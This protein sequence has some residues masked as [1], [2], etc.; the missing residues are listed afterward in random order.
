MKISCCW[1]YAIGKYG[2]PPQLHQMVQA[3]QDM[4]DLGF[5]HVELEGVGF[6]NLRQVIDNRERLKEAVHQAG[7]QV[8]DFAP[9]LPE[10]ISLDENVRRRAAH[11]IERW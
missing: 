6:Q 7:V 3:I 4:A 10:V 11:P 1:M 8:V 2:F 5:E 9:L